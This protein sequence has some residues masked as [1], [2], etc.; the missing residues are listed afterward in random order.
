MIVYR[1]RFLAGMACLTVLFPLNGLAQS[2]VSE[3]GEAG[4]SFLSMAPSARI[5]ALGGEGFAF[6]EGS[7]S[8]WSNPAAI[9][10]SERNAVDFTHTAWIGGTNHEYASVVVPGNRS[11]F[12]A[13]VQ[14]F[15]SG[16]MDGRDQYG[17]AT[18]DYSVTNAGISLAYA[19]PL[20]TWFSM[21]IAARKLFE[22]VAGET[23]GGYAFDAGIMAK[24]PV[25]GLT[26]GATARNYGKMNKL[27][28]EE[29]KLP[30]NIGIG[31]SY[32]GTLPVFLMPCTF[33]A[34]FIFPRFGDNGCHLG[35]EISATE[36]FVLRL[37]YRNDS[38]FETMS[39]GIG[40]IWQNVNADIAY[41]PL[42]NVSDD[43][44]RFT[45]SAAGF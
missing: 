22:K 9:A 29:T 30:S 39:Y 42:N 20:T 3:S 19:R 12:G 43:A 44:L 15:D 38:S 37:G 5:A 25:D 2:Q 27:L 6:D 41:S 17:A 16:N 8:Q 18:G 34:D 31:A 14:L 11:S 21:G 28:T 7:S 24:T 40:F 10:F 4:M 1:F 33:L 35:L 36:G 32:A 26:L 45:L 13:S 23:A